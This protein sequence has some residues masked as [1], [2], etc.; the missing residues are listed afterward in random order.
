MRHS[1]VPLCPPSH[2]QLFLGKRNRG[3]KTYLLDLEMEDPLCCNFLSS[4]KGIGSYML[5]KYHPNT[6]IAREVVKGYSGPSEANHWANIT[7]LS[8]PTLIKILKKG[9]SLIPLRPPSGAQW[10]Q[11]FVCQASLHTSG[12]VQ[13]LTLLSSF[14]QEM[15]YLFMI[16]YLSIFA[17]V[18]IYVH[19]WPRCN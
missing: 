17:F 14:L 12:L 15:L 2:P 9:N 10:A 16:L 13:I 8:F 11:S 19:L 3:T 4:S 5:S 6:Q 1:K 18:H 7:C